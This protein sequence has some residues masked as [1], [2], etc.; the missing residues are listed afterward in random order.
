MSEFTSSEILEYHRE[1][2]VS[3]QNALQAY[4]DNHR[5]LLNATPGFR[6]IVKEW[7]RVS[8]DSAE[9]ATIA[10]TP[11]DAVVFSAFHELRWAS[12]KRRATPEQT[13]FAVKP[14]FELVNSTNTLPTEAKLVS[15]S[16]A[17]C[18]LA[19]KKFIELRGIV[20]DVSN[21]RPQTDEQPNVWLYRTS[22]KPIAIEK[23]DNSRSALLLEP[24][25]ILGGIIPAASI[26]TVNR[27]DKFISVGHQSG[28]TNLEV[29]DYCADP[30]FGPLRLSPWAH[31]NPID[32]ALF[33][34]SKEAGKN[35]IVDLKR[36]EVHKTTISD[37]V[38]T[39]NQ[40]L[41][42]CGVAA[43]QKVA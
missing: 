43:Q 41:K 38:L 9:F 34:V 25:S 32:R 10:P 36:A 2:F 18:E 39:A 11:L 12:G 30:E 42:I 20:D 6:N 23:K 5:L 13:M 35:P 17:T 15:W 28:Q 16:V 1:R 21:E 37:F 26:V 40:I 14:L 7:N 3:D 22:K 24:A 8:Y 27:N 31:K 29:L 33:G 4:L 19:E